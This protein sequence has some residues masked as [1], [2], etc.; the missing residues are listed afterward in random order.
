VSL[1]NLIASASVLKRQSGATGP[2]VSSLVMTKSVFHAGD[3]AEQLGESA[4]RGRY[5]L[6]IDRYGRTRGQQTPGN[7][8]K[9]LE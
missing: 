9:F 8:A 5:R 7:L 1:A 6:C 2:K 4:R 3:L